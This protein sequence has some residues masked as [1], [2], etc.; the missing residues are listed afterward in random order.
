MTNEFITLKA[1]RE[2]VY[3]FEVM[4]SEIVGNTH[5]FDPAIKDNS[6]QEVET[7]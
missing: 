1:L 4:L 2:I 6:A 3:I 7:P 5:G